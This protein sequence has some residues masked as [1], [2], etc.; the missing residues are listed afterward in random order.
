MRFLEKMRKNKSL[1]A[2]RYKDNILQK[3]NQTCERQNKSG[4]PDFPYLKYKLFLKRILYIIKN[5][6]LEILNQVTKGEKNNQFSQKIIKNLLQNLKQDLILIYE[7]KKKN[8][9]NI[10]INQNIVINKI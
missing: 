2:L 5:S 9:V 8:F 4:K 3:I 1:L 6:Q 10:D 7:N